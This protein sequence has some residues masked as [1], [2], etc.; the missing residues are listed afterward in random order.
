MNDGIIIGIDFGTT[1]TSISQMDYYNGVLMPICLKFEGGNSYIKTLITYISNENYYIG[2]EARNIQGDNLKSIKRKIVN[3]EE[4]GFTKYHKN[5]EDV[6]G[7]FLKGIIDNVKLQFRSYIQGVVFGVPIGITDANKKLYL[8]ALVKSEIFKNYDIA[9]KNTIFVSEPIG[10]ALDYATKLTDDKKILVFDFGGGTLDMIITQTK[11][12]ISKNEISEQEIL[13]KTDG[14]KIGGDDFDEIILK[15]IVAQKV[16][17][18]KLKQNL[19]INS[20]ADIYKTV[21]GRNLMD[22]ITYA[23]EKLSTVKVTNINVQLS[24]Y[25]SINVQVTKEEFENAIGNII[26]E[27][28]LKIDEC[29]NSANNKSG[30]KPQDIDIVVMAG[31]SS[32]IPKVQD[33]LCSKFGTS[34]VKINDDPM[35]S[36]ARGL[37]LRGHNQQN[38][39][40]NDIAEH[41]YGVKVLNDN[42]MVQIANITEKNQKIEDINSGKYYFEFELTDTAKTNNFFRINICSDKNEC[43]VVRVPF[44]DKK[45]LMQ[46]STF[47]LHFVINSNLGILETKIYDLDREKMVDIPISDN[48]RIN[49]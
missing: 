48:E 32:L 36:I 16:G 25:E 47:K 42:G 41:S 14:L 46:D 24:T 2:K 12:I 6:I 4:L 1:N 19:K 31:G 13:A 29:L 15:D 17:V 33:L 18:E 38:I 3:N 22:S 5:E 40:I 49:L 30:L 45:A 23:K 8:K 20:F 43:G 35:T 21:E 11:N 9:K 34:K 26:K 27:I 7:D 39:K 28:S 37:A 44:E 10:A